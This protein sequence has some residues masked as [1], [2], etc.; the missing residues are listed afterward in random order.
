MWE[1]IKRNAK[2]KIY[3]FIEKDGLVVMLSFVILIILVAIAFCQKAEI[4][5]VVDLTVFSGIVFAMALNV[6]SK[7]FKKSILNRFED[8]VKLTTE[9]KKLC[10]KYQ[11]DLYC[12]KNQDGKS[13]CFPVAQF[14]PLKGCQIEIRDTDCMYQLPETIQEHFDEIFSAHQTSKI[15]NRLHVRV[16]DW[17]KEGNTFYLSTS[18]TTY[19]NS[20]VTNRAMDF[21]WEN[22]LT[23]REALEYGP[24]LHDLSTSELSNHLGFNGFIMSNDNQI[25][26]I[27][28]DDD[29]SIGKKTCGASINAALNTEHALEKDGTFQ[30]QGLVATILHKIEDELKISSTDLKTFDLNKNLI[31]VY[32]DLV[33]GGKPQLLFYVECHLDRKDIEKKFYQALGKN[34]WVK[35]KAGSDPLE[36]GSKILWIKKEELHSVYLDVDKMIHNNKKYEMTPSAA[37]S[38]GMFI[39]VILEENGGK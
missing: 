38:F 5:D 34:Y 16:D 9:Y 19:Y 7:V 8:D 6:L 25:P 20:M 4:T 31:A 18:R 10:K 2:K 21:P 35:R 11:T 36:D 17:G 32:R 13:V 30:S 29:L 24:F 15:Y 22:G 28:R 3:L 14:M 27:K 37:A 1:T 39:D 23:V 26:L 33:E 12:Y